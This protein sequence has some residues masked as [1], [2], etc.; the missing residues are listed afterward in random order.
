MKQ[1]SKGAGHKAS[2]PKIKR[3]NRE[4]L[5]LEARDRKRQKK[6][7]GHAAGS[8]AQA[9]GGDQHNAS[10]GKTKDPRIGSKKPVSLLPEGAAVVVKA[11]VASQ[12]KPVRLP[13]QEELEMLENDPRLD[14]LLDRLE[15]GE[16]LPAKEQSWLDETLD[17]IDILMEQLG[18]SLDDDEEDEEQEEDMLQLLRRNNPKD[19][20]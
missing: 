13:P 17:R 6:H 9:S 20:H 16:T 11:P 5:D 1:P 8:R 14:A 7:R 15:K 10:S 18:I 12:E 19:S 2:A 3:K 4:Q